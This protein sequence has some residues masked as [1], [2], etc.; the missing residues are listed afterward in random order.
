MFEEIPPVVHTHAY[1]GFVK[2]SEELPVGRLRRSLEE[3]SERI[4]DFMLDHVLP[5]NPHLTW[6][7][8]GVSHDG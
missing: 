2:D 5:P 4:G 6:R 7:S 1:P 8:K 3:I